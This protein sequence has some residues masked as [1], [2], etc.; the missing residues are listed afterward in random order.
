M[1][2]RK[3]KKK[4]YNDKMYH[5]DCTQDLKITIIERHIFSSRKLQEVPILGDLEKLNLQ[6]WHENIKKLIN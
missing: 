1:K 3:R 6:L 2:V 5:E 4:V